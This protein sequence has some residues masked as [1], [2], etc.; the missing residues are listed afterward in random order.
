MQNKKDR[1]IFPIQTKTA[2]KLKWSWSSIYLTT[3]TTASCH[4]THKHKFD[5]DSF[6]FHNTPEEIADRE[7]MLQGEWPAIGCDY[8][9]NIESA[10]GQSD[11]ITNL[12]LHGFESPPEL[13]HDKNATIVT[14]TI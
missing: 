10:G 9:K 6:N 7:K 14:P 5:V 12:E 4:R 11:R 3:E 2:C 13:D 8:C 1:Y